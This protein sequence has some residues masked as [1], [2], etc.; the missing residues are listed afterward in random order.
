MFKSATIKLTGWYLALIMGLS[1][2]FSVVLYHS[3]SDSISTGFEHQRTA[4]R[5]QF[6][7]YGLTPL[8]S[9]LERLQTSE[10]SAAEQHL[11]ANLT[12]ANIAVFVVGG[13]FSF[14]M[15]RRTLLPIERTMEAQTRFTADASHELRTPLT[16]M[17]TEI[18]VALRDTKLPSKEARALL[19]SNLEEVRRLQ[20]LSDGLLALANQDEEHFEPKPVKSHQVFTSAIARVA[21]VAEQKHIIIKNNAEHLEILGDKDSLI[22]LFMILLD[23]AIKYSAPG[24]TIELAAYGK[25]NN[26]YLSITDHG[27]GIEAVDLPH[28]FERLYRA[29]SSRSKEKIGGYG[30]GLSIAKKIVELHKGAVDATSKMGE[31]STF[32]VRIPLAQKQAEK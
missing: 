8:P 29:D 21:K 5:K 12:L 3:S 11:I 20:D 30:L 4:L 15:A 2:A 7:Y 1:I 31:G 22:Q 26:A 28:I 32:T 13:A 18:E 14:Y 23:N 27:Y 10:I 6:E 16:A 17:Q 9:S 24:K 25:N 19:E